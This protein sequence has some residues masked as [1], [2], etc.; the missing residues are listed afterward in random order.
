MSK[1]YYLHGIG[2][3]GPFSKEELAKE[4]LSRDTLIWYYGLN[5][6]TKLSKLSELKHLAYSIPPA[7]KLKDDLVEHNIISGKDQKKGGVSATTAQK[8]ANRSNAFRWVIGIA[9][10]V[11]VIFVFRFSEQ[12]D[13]D[14]ELYNKISSNAYQ[15]EED[16]G[17]Y[18]EKFYRDLEFYGIYPKR[19][20]TNLIQFSKLDQIEDATHIHG[21]SYGYGDD[22]QIEIYI[23]PSTWDSFNK[24]MRYFLMYHELAHDVLNVDDLSNAELNQNDLMYPELNKYEGK[25]MDDFIEAS[26]ALF[27]RYSNK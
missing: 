20:R 7:L 22:D 3:R 1:Y 24:P 16:F 15:A 8:V 21:V 14:M 12:T 18:V 5:D 26:T 2:K 17:M 13:V 9:S 23:N 19:P 11:F 6:W 4:L 25:S 10:I 27:E